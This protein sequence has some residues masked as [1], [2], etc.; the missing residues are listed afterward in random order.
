MRLA[1]DAEAQGAFGVVV[2]APMSN[3][4]I[5]MVAE[6]IDIPIIATVLH[7][8]TDIQ[9]R[10]DAGVSI[11][12]VSAAERTPEVVRAIR[13]KFPRVPII[14]TGGPT[15]KTIAPTIVLK[16]GKPWMALGSPGSLA[17]PPA[18]AATLNNVILY[19]MELQE[20]INQPRALGTTRAEGKSHQLSIE[21]DLFSA[22]NTYCWAVECGILN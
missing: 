16:E 12:N 9:A 10:L 4:T 17:I 13:E 14:A 6:S 11:L 19:G 18:V 22:Y 20:A 1:M 8:K 15:G 7:E 3:D 5:R 2:N 21:N